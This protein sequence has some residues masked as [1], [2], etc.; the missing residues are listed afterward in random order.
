MAIQDPLTATI[1]GAAIEVSKRLGVGLFEQVY[2]ECLS[3]ELE[4]LGLDVARQQTMPV[5]YKGIAL[6]LG[7]RADLIVRGQVI[8]E[9][10]AIA[11]TLPIHEAQL[12]NYMRLSGMRTGL[13]LNF[14]AFPFKK[15]IKRKVL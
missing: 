1:I 8:V 15:G 6:K 2:Q 11:T 12:L 4:R 14:H 10:K 13:L 3:L 9:V 7:Y 5:V